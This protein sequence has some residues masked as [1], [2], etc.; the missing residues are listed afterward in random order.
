MVI[1]KKS[2]A[3]VEKEEKIVKKVREK[4]VRMSIR[5]KGNVSIIDIPESK[6]KDH[7]KAGWK[8]I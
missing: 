2:V 3:K 8:V 7:E 4:L 5:Y 6:V 1:E